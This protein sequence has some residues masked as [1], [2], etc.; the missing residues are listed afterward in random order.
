MRAL[1][2]RVTHSRV[3]VGD[4]VIGEIGSGLTILLGISSEDTPQIAERM[5]DK[6]AHLR[7]FADAAGKTNL[8]AAETHAEMLVISQFTLYADLRRGRRPG[9]SYAARPE[10]AEPLYEV[11]VAALTRRGFRTARGRFGADMVVELANDGPFT[12]LL[13]SNEFSV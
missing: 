12:L 1:L 11:F 9:F 2:Q 6:I 5:A 10:L 3:R 7:I 8:S 4:D 13:D